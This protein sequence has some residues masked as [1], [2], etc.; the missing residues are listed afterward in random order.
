[1]VFG[2]ANLAANMAR[3]LVERG[4]FVVALAYSVVLMGRAR[5]RIQ[6]SAAHS[7]DD[8]QK[9]ISAFV[10]ARDETGK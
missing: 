5:I 3:K 10:S 2:D 6:V 1:M 4:V 8:L 7:R 9:A